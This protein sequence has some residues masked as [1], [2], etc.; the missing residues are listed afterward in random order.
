ML[1][2]PPGTLGLS[3][4]LVL[5]ELLRPTVKATRETSPRQIAR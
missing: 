2:A 5:L 1:S 3:K 4:I